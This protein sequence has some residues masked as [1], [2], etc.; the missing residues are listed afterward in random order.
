[1]NHGTMSLIIESPS[2]GVTVGFARIDSIESLLPEEAVGEE[3]RG[4]VPRKI[5]LFPEAAVAPQGVQVISGPQRGP[6]PTTLFR[7][8]EVRRF[9]AHALKN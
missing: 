8:A 3:G 4:M 7:K 2:G 6:P 1:M 9:E 5:N